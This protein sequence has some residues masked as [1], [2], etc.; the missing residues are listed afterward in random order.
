MG[1]VM[2]GSTVNGAAGIGKKRKVLIGI[3][4]LAAAAVAAAVFF[5]SRPMFGEENNPRV[6]FIQAEIG[7]GGES[8]SCDIPGE[9]ISDE[10]SD[11]LV[12]LFLDAEMRNRLLPRPQSY[13]IEDGSVY[14]FIGVSLEQAEDLS[15]IVN[16]CN[17]PDYSSAQF[18]DTHYRI[19]NE[20]ALYQEV[21]DL[22]SDVLPAYAVKR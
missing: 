2:L 9:E 3:A 11:A 17:R 21:Y 6:K 22:L 10:L 14:L 5:Q 19:V 15:M 8:Y 20:Q 7:Q 13:H 16:L 1:N 4:V 12:S 18:G